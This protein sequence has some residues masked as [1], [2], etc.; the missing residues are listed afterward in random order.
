MRIGRFYFARLVLKASFYDCWNFADNAEQGIHPMSMI[1]HVHMD[2]SQTP[3]CALAGSVNIYS[4]FGESKK[5]SFKSV[6]W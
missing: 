1:Y 5:K 3:T 4:G 2:Y 6:L